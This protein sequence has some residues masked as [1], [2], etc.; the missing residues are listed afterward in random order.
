M[1]RPGH[2]SGAMWFKNVLNDHKRT[3][4]GLF[5]G[6]QNN[7]PQYGQRM[8]CF[9]SNLGFNMGYIFYFICGGCDRRTKYLYWYEYTRPPLCRECCFVPYANPSKKAKLLF[10]EP[11]TQRPF[12]AGSCWWEPVILARADTLAAQKELV[13]VRRR[14]LP[15]IDA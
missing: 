7:G 10:L 15:C 3:G 12:L 14:K 8:T 1:L 11:K 2:E 6:L 13:P 5:L 4:W 9:P